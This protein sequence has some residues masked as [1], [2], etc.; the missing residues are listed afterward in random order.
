MGHESR[1]C[2]TMFLPLGLLTSC[3]I[4][5][6]LEWN[7]TTHKHFKVVRTSF[8]PSRWTGDSLLCGCWWGKLSS[9]LD[10]CHMIP[11]I[12]GSECLLDFSKREGNFFFF[13]LGLCVQ[14]AKQ[15][16]VQHNGITRETIP[17]C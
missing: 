16:C 4:S 17:L 5:W 12:R 11:S 1:H 14:S 7:R 15:S 6:R 8:T 9:L 13:Q 2:L 3:T 10:S